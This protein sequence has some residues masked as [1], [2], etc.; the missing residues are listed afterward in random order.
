VILPRV[1]FVARGVLLAS[2]LLASCRRPDPA[3]E[4]AIS[5]LEAY[6]VVDAP[7]GD[8]QYLAPAVRLLIRNATSEPQRSLEVTAVFRRKGEEDKTWGSDWR[9]VAPSGKPL[10]PGKETLVVLKSDA[11]YTSKGGAPEGMFENEAFRDAVAEVFVRL[12]S[13]PW[14]KVGQIPVERHIGA[15]AASLVKTAP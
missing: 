4:L 6:W 13:S 14:Y 12:G 5:G 8:T 9:R 10:L 7:V 3:K 11:R 2:L 15:R 1:P